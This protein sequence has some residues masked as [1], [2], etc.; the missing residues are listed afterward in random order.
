MPKIRRR[1]LP[2][3]LRD[4]TKLA[5]R[6]AKL[7]PGVIVAV[8]TQVVARSAD[9]RPL[10]GWHETSGP[11]ILIE[12]WERGVVVLPNVHW[13][14]FGTYT[15]VRFKKDSKLVEIMISPLNIM[16]VQD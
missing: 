12:R 2:H 13:Q 15:L 4:E 1:A 16:P 9:H 5:K 11:Q 10:M 7:S 6:L 14:G 8:T 3:D